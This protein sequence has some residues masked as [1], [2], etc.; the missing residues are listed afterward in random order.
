MIE[1]IGFVINEAM[2]AA[3]PE[4]MSQRWISKNK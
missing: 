1:E 4:G 3:A 2:N